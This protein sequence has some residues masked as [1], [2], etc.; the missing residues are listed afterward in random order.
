MFGKFSK[1]LSIGHR[2][3]IGF[4]LMLLV[5]GLVVA[6]ATIGI[7]YIVNSA[8]DLLEN[9]RLRTMLIEREVDHLEWE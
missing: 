7:W 8:E 2:I 4:T 1:G 6:I 9:N 3:G 5:L